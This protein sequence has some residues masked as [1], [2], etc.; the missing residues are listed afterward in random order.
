MLKA[1]FLTF[2]AMQ[3]FLKVGGEVDAYC[4]SC[5]MELAHTVL[6]MVGARVA[7]VRCNTCQKYHA[8]RKS[9]PGTSSPRPENPTPS[10]PKTPA[11]SPISLLQQLAG[12]DASKARNYSP[13]ESFAEGELLNHPTFG[14]GFVQTV[15]G[16]KIDVA[17]KAF[18]KTLI[19]QKMPSAKTS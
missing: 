3:P 19:H 14:L 7:R 16:E 1:S 2:L 10:R 12:A 4:I 17:F 5:R 8:F 6:A 9:A 13:K 11:G 18:A 15:R